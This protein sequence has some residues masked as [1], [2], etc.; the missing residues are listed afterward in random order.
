M[1][2][3]GGEESYTWR[4]V[5]HL[6]SEILPPTGREGFDDPGEVVTCGV[7]V[8]EKS[9]HKKL[10]AARDSDDG[11]DFQHASCRLKSESG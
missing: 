5:E 7:E 11:S 9:R 8:A 3:R 2:D 10:L 4:L 6:F 1:R